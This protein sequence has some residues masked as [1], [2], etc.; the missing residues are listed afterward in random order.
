MA[1]NAKVKVK[2]ESNELDAETFL[3]KKLGLANFS[4]FPKSYSQSAII[5]LME[6]YA[7][8]KNGKA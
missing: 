5:E 3:R 7:K 6:E 8:Y 1:L 2:T 4:F